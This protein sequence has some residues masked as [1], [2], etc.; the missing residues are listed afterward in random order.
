MP[1]SPEVMNIRQAADYLGISSDT[2]YKYL[3]D[4]RIPAFKLGNRWKFKKSVLDR[5]MERQ[6]FPVGSAQVPAR[7]EKGRGSR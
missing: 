4:E 3:A 1:D 2:L 5:W 6:S 7:E